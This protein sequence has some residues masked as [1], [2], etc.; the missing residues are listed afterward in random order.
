MEPKETIPIDGFPPVTKTPKRVTFSEASL[1]SESLSDTVTMDSDICNDEPLVSSAIASLDVDPSLPPYDPKTN[2]LSP[3]KPKLDDCYLFELLSENLSDTDGSES[4]LTEDLLEES[5]G[6]SS[7]EAFTE[8][9][10][11]QEEEPAMPV[12]K[13]ID[14]PGLPIAEDISEAKM[15]SKSRFSTILRFLSLMLVLMIAFLSFSVTDS[16][17]LATPGS[18]IDLRFSNVSIPSAIPVLAFLVLAKANSYFKQFSS[19]VVSYFSK[20]IND[21]G[22]I[23][24]EELDKRFEPIELEEDEESETEPDEEEFQMDADLDD[25]GEVEIKGVDVLDIEEASVIQLAEV[26]GADIL[27]KD[28]EQGKHDLVETEKVSVVPTEG[29]ESDSSERYLDQG[30]TTSNVEVELDES[31]SFIVDN[32]LESMID[33]PES[34]VKEI[35]AVE[36]AQPLEM[37]KSPIRHDEDNV[38]AYQIL[39]VSSLVLGLLAGTVLYVKRRS[40]KTLHPVVF[41]RKKFATHHVVKEKHSS[42]NWPTEVDVAGAKKYPKS[43]DDEAQ[44]IEKKPRKSNRRESLVASEFSMGSPS[45]GSFT[46]CERIP[47]KH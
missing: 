38:G 24:S 13:Q 21:L 40:D 23:S 29:N 17:I 33:N 30:L 14:E 18:I 43:E 42:Q 45:Y 28:V 4:S 39:G 36:E 10:V 46:T 9:T 26:N 32:A 22:S 11:D 41:S 20:L 47:A 27:E 1:N 35:S 6:S 2:Y 34:I 12:A 37:M 5:D 31:Q 19:E 16:P 15:K 8:A 3:M 44:S 25:G 7:E